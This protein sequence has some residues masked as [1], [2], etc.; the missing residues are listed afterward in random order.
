MEDLPPDM[1]CKARKM[2]AD[3]FIISYIIFIWP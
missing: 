1:E 3:A 2:M